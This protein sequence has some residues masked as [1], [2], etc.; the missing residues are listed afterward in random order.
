M[1]YNFVRGGFFC[2]FGGAEGV[3]VHLSLFFLMYSILRIP[4]ED[5]RKNKDARRKK[6]IRKALYFFIGWGEGCFLLSFIYW[7]QESNL[8]FGERISYIIL[9]RALPK[10]RQKS[11]GRSRQRHIRHCTS[12]PW[13]GNGGG[14]GG[15][16][17]GCCLHN[18]WNYFCRVHSFVCILRLYT[19]INWSQS[20]FWN[21]FCYMINW[22]FPLLFSVGLSQN[23]FQISGFSPTTPW[24]QSNCLNYQNDLQAHVSGLGEVVVGETVQFEGSSFIT[25]AEMKEKILKWK[26]ELFLASEL[27][28][29]PTLGLWYFYEWR[30]VTIIS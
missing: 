8:C 16:L 15:I 2:F 22:E 5:W 11:E 27:L 26:Q 14:R 7:F 4:R 9:F 24:L 21:Y 25:L 12:K 30:M 10:P 23:Y 29:E 6:N 3:G 17:P 19:I 20:M 28:G 18:L 13:G 1:Y